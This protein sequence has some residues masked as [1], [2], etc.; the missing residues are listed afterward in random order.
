[1]ETTQP[2]YVSMWIGAETITAYRGKLSAKYVVNHKLWFGTD[3]LYSSFFVQSTFWIQNI[4][5]T[6]SI[7]LQWGGGI[8]QLRNIS[9][10]LCSHRGH[11]HRIKKIRHRPLE[12]KPL[13][14]VSP[15]TLSHYTFSLRILTMH[16]LASQ[17]HFLANRYTLDW[18]FSVLP[19]FWQVNS[20]N[21]LLK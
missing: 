8:K 12:S 7:G 11:V 18:V 1:M 19:L 16:V 14:F 21:K 4:F 15:H 3:V 17:L 10:G 2:M 9:I 5:N 20:Y 13:T 6:E